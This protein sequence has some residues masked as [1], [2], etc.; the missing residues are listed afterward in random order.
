VLPINEIRLV[1]NS[2]W[3]ADSLA[4][5]L[6]SYIPARR[7]CARSFQSFQRSSQSP[8]V[9]VAQEGTGAL[10]RYNGLRGGGGGGRG[11]GAGAARLLLDFDVVGQE[12]GDAFGESFGQS[13][14]DRVGCDVRGG[15]GGVVRREEG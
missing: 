15:E 8:S 3:S 10:R 13:F 5:V 2:F 6:Y 1:V 11:G 4:L 14:G 7:S 9:S 12:G